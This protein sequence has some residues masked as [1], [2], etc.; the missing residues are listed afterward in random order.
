MDPVASIVTALATG[1][2]AGLSGTASQMVTDGYR[3]L[4]A[5]VRRKL[6]GRPGADAMIDGHEHDSG[7]WR[8]R[9]IA[10]LTES[11]AGNDAGL[12]AAARA[13]LSLTEGAAAKCT[14]DARGGQGVQIGD[15]GH[16]DN[17]FGPAGALR[18]ARP[19]VRGER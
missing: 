13:L 10:E 4:K 8:P 5:L 7:A 2:A 11:G 14:V 17:A 15:H 3:E 19:E 18:T 6:A 9:L 12:A 1:A 16:Q